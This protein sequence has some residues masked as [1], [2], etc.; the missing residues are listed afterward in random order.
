MALDLIYKKGAVNGLKL[1]L[2]NG[3]KYDFTAKIVIDASGFYST[4][5]NKLKSSLIEKVISKEERSLDFLKETVSKI[6]GAI[7]ETQKA[8]EK[9]F[10]VLRMKLPE[11]ITFMHTEDL[12][13]IYP[14]LSPKEREFEIAKKYGAV[15]LIGIGHPLKSGKPHDIR[16]ADYDDWSTE[17]FARKRGLCGDIIIWDP[18][19]KDALELS[20]MGIRVDK[21]A[22]ERQLKM[23]GEEKKKS[24]EF[25]KAIL[26]DKMILSIGGGIGQS[27]LCML[28]LHK[29]NFKKDS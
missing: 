7:R 11:K 10:P 5:R 22:L 9:E 4:L 13:K 20:S 23:M 15:F 3:E 1:K 27:R 26:S 14:E 21:E 25:H 12:E 2:E 16:A 19:R 29:A 24:L 6:Y 8:I 28:L 17:T 18:L